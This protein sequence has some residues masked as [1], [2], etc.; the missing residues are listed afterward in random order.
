MKRICYLSMAVALTAILA[1]SA[2][3]WQA[4]DSNPFSFYGPNAV[5][6]S[7]QANASQATLKYKPGLSKGFVTFQYSLP[8]GA[9]SAKLNIYNLS[10]SLIESFDLAAG[11]TSKVWSFGSRKA[12]AGIYLATMRCGSFENKIQISIVK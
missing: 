1:V 3:P 10:G 12:A 6:F 9:K 2:T 7:K 8:A 11:T 5:R 4:I